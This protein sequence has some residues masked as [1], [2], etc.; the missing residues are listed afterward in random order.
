MSGLS[1]TS[2]PS[3]STATVGITLK[4]TAK[5]TF[6]TASVKTIGSEDEDSTVY[7]FI[8][9]KPSVDEFTSIKTSLQNIP[10]SFEWK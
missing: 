4:I 10:S 8:Y 7:N 5:N 3:T 2:F 9:D 1:I 6:G